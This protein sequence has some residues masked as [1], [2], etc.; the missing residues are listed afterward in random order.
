MPGPRRRRGSRLAQVV[1][2][3]LGEGFFE[4]RH[5]ADDH[6]FHHLGHLSLR[7]NPQGGV[8]GEEALHLPENFAQLP[9]FYP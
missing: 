5:P 6:A 9:F 2:R 4:L 7:H 3:N 1:I 8:L